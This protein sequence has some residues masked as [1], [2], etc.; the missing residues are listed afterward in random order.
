LNEQ[1]QL[2]ALPFEAGVHPESARWNARLARFQWVDIARGAVFAFDPVTSDLWCHELGETVSAVFPGRNWDV[3]AR[4]DRLE[5]LDW[6]SGETHTVAELPVPP[7]SRLNDG[8]SDSHGTIWVGSMNSDG[9]PDGGEL[10][11]V[12]PDGRTETVLK[13][14]GISNGIGW[15][16]DGMKA[17]YVDSLTG[18]VDAL[19]LGRD[20]SPVNRRPFADLAAEGTPD[21]LAVAGDGGLWV[22]MWDG[23]CVVKVDVHGMVIERLSVPARRPSSL[24]FSNQGSMI[25]TSARVGLTPEELEDS[26]LSGH[27]FFGATRHRALPT[28]L[29]SFARN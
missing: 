21:G 2:K 16:G 10:Y 18:R 4:R 14:V 22:A 20:G 12:W 8:A 28:H 9:G 27:V 25:V 29:H 1:V 26:P 7:S 3:V 6:T 11:R 15:S 24:A 19:E 13:S 23:S 5:V 17:Y